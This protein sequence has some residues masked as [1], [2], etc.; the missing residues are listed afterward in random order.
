MLTVAER[1]NN[2]VFLLLSNSIAPIRKK[3]VY[4]LIDKISKEDL[5][6][7]IIIQKAIIEN[8]IISE[9]KDLIKICEVY[10]NYLISQR[11]QVRKIWKSVNNN[12]EIINNFSNMS[13]SE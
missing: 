9:E 3:I 11:D 2:M 6:K 4:Y 8:F 1:T 10:R 5:E 7:Q 13:V 12:A